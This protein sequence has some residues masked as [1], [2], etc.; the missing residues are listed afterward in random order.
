MRCFIAIHIDEGVRSALS[1]LQEELKGCNVDIR[2]VRP[3]N[4]H[5]TLKF[6]GDVKE[7]RLD[8]IRARLEDICSRYNRFSLEARGMG[9]FPDKKRPRVLWV[10][11]D[12][13]GNLKGLQ[14]DIE[15]AMATIGFKKEDRAFTP[16]LTIGR[17]RSRAGIDALY[18][19]MQSY[20]DE[21]F[22]LFDVRS[23]FLM[24][25]ILRPSGAEYR[26]VAEFGLR[27]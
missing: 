3:E 5:L 13:N 17:F 26:R 20:M 19:R 27:V 22:G 1:G 7:D 10:D 25:S 21:R 4:I 15:E 6:L 8:M 9:I 24:E 14:H 18:D 2:W 16:H 23:V 11:V 12:G